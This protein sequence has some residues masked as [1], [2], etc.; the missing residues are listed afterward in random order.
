MTA[1][2]SKARRLVG[3]KFKNFALRRNWQGCDTAL[4]KKWAA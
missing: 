3:A 1:D 4:G 2:L